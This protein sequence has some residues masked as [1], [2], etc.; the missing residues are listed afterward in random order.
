MQRG[1]SQEALAFQRPQLFSKHEGITNNQSTS[2]AIR[3][4]VLQGLQIGRI[5]QESK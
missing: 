3:S 5:K 4:Q 1:A 2:V